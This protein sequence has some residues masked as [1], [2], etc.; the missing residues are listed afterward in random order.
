MSH[1][2]DINSNH[3]SIFR[4]SSVPPNHKSKRP[5]LAP[6]NKTKQNSRYESGYTEYD[7]INEAHDNPNTHNKSSEPGN[8]IK[9]ARERCKINK[10]NNY[11]S[12]IY[13]GKWKLEDKLMVHVY[14]N[15]N[16]KKL[17]FC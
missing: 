17:E 13:T 11:F 4:S 8:K 15:Y 2:N 6:Q 9:A 14:E 10:I 5:P 3:N 16:T 1:N 7:E 12:N